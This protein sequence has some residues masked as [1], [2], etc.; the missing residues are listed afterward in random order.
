M[1]HT[2]YQSNQQSNMQQLWSTRGR[3]SLGTSLLVNKYVSTAMLGIGLMGSMSSE[4]MAA[5]NNPGTQ[6]TYQQIFLWTQL[7]LYVQ[8]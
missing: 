8:T 1:I 4:D 6:S 2:E 3:L 5:T 7:F